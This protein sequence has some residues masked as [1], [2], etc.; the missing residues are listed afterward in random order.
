[1]FFMLKQWILG[2]ILFLGSFTVAFAELIPEP[3][4]PATPTPSPAQ[5]AGTAAEGIEIPKAPTRPNITAPAGAT[6]TQP[7]PNA[8]FYIGTG[9]SMLNVQGFTGLIPKLIGGFGFLFGHD[10]KLYLGTEIFVAAGMV[11]LSHNQ[12]KRISALLAASIQPGYKINNWTIVF[13][14]LGAEGARFNKLHSTQIGGLAGVGFQSNV[15]PHW[16]MRAE[17]D[18]NVPLNLNQYS[19]DFIYKFC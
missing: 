16:D 17:Y 3:P 9:A 19:L 11:P 12:Y 15:I 6:P 14:R 8:S 18:Y 4:A 10:K 1:M 13:L 2:I 7:Q 5:A